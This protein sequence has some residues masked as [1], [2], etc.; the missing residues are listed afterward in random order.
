MIELENTAVV[1][2][3]QRSRVIVALGSGGVGK[4]TSSAVMAVIGASLGKK[5]G[6]L[7]I[8]PAKRLADALGIKLG[9]E[10]SRVHLDEAHAAKGEIYG[11]M[12]DQKAVFDEMVDRFAP[13]SNIRNRIYANSI[14]K[15]VSQNLGGPLEYM[16]LA[17]LQNM[18]AD[19]SFD[20]IVLDT[21]PD[22]HALDFLMRPN[23]LAGFMEKRVMTWLIKP[24]HFAQ[25]LG[26]GRLIKAGGRLMSG[27]SSITGVKMLQMLS[28]FLVLMEDVIKGFNSAGEKVSA[29]LREPT[30]NFVLISAPH[31]SAV[32]SSTNLL[33]EL[34]QNQYP[35]GALLI[36]RCPTQEMAQSI[37]TWRAEPE[38][39][40]DYRDGLE[41]IESSYQ[42][43]EK[44]VK[45]MQVQASEYFD[46]QA[47]IILIEEQKSMIHSLDSLFAF[48][49]VVA[50]SPSI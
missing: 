15:E 19:E 26:A 42:H 29:L 3:V 14:Y 45:E 40:Q 21:P 5:V 38:K 2:L 17:K 28:E 47:P 44:A 6:L 41:I 37:R 31:N 33:K 24:F 46:K 43:Y 8:D 7:S 13:S 35:L 34:H 30:T 25:K 1:D 4:T 23:V 39:W 27:I 16:A 18:V 22:T 20:L 9:S 50:N 49:K 10:L 12:L 11:A 36:N 48:S 32:R